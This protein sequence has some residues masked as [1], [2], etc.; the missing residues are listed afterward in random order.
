MERFWFG[1]VLENG[2]FLVWHNFSTSKRKTEEC[3]WLPVYKQ[4]KW[5]VSGYLCTS[6]E[7][8][9]FLVTSLQAEKMECF[10]LPVYK[11]RKWNISV[12]H[13]LSL[14]AS[15]ENGTF[16]FGI[17]CVQAE[18]MECFWLPVYKQRKWKVSGYLC[19][20]RENGTFLVTCAQ[21]EKMERLWLA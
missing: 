19:T 17:T 14:S 20:N 6:R 13:N 16:L 4:R 5:N 8:G 18:K 1:Q 21:A 3:F 12:W 2:M 15:R 9:M 7:N 10:W 11:Q